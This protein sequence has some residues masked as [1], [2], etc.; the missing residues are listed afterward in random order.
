MSVELIFVIILVLIFNGC[1]ITVP[2]WELMCLAIKLGG[3]IQK[4]DELIHAL[5]IINLIVLGSMPPYLIQ[6]YEILGVVS[7]LMVECS[8]IIFCAVYIYHLYC[9]VENILNSH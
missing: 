2:L 1:I 8:Y 5:I 6:Y 3:S 4:R 7:I 9:A